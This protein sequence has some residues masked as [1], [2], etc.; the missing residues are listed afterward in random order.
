MEQRIRRHHTGR[1]LYAVCH[2]S[3]GWIPTCVGM[4]RAAVLTILLIIL[5]LFSFA[6]DKLT[7]T[8]A[9]AMY[10]EPKYKEDFKHFDYVNPNAPK[11]GA[12]KL[13]ATGS[14]DNLNFFLLKGVAPAGISMITESLTTRSDDE[15][16]S[17]YGLIAETMEVPE[18]RSYIIFNMRKEAKFQDGSL[19]T[20]D[21]VVFSFYTLKEKGHPVYKTYYQDI[22][23]VEKLDDRRVK[24]VF[25][26]TKNR[27]LPL[28]AGQMPILSKKYY[29]KV[30]FEK[31]TLTAPMG[32]GPYKVAAV[33]AGRSVTY[34]LDPNYWGKDLPVRIG[35]NNFDTIRY[36]YYRDD[37]VA[38]EAFKAGEY[39]FRQENIARNW[40]TA[41]D[42]PA[43]HNGKAKKEEIGH[44]IP[45][46]MQCFVFN[47]RRGK[48]ADKKLREALNMAFDFE[49]TNKNLFYG[50]Y[51]RTNSYFSN[52]EFASSGLPQGKELEI[53]SEY[54]DQLPEEVFGKE[55]V[56]PVSDGSGQ[57]R[58]LLVAAKNLLEEA[59]W[60]V[61]DGKLVNQ[62]GE[63]MNIEFL[64]NS[65]SFE[66]VIAPYI[67]NLEKLGIT[68]KIRMVD[69]AQYQKRLEEFDF[70][71]IM[72]VFPESMSPG[73]EQLDYWSSARADINGS[74][75][76]IGLK[77]KVVDAL[78]DKLL[79]A[80]DKESLVASAR[81]LDRVLLWG[82][83]VVPN[84]HIRSFRIIYWNK[85]GKPDVQPTYSLGFDNWWINGN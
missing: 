67:R 29:D 49:W 39:D 25:S 81:A 55:F 42:F 11:G 46:G 31:T 76:Y 1:R 66:R 51:T 56:L 19:V 43:L 72:N 58:K 23:S 64:I 69:T 38:V 65:P 9:I 71:V 37:T 75:N 26:N 22:S 80:N 83:Y 41:Y 68:G 36:D 77:N 50:A 53:L 30:D 7:K 12:V 44:S 5:P 73:N 63:G 27:E 4:T 20:A 52:S 15:P 78:V 61:K 82:Y 45:T 24:F 79:A 14:F 60:K 84:W 8:H 16:F 85:F 33:D 57:D 59:G 13:A 40:A 74:Q 62:K 47:T 35:T 54:K 3:L 17:Q 21:D 6:E 34:K 32:S 28:I 70:D 48:F 18:D 2:A 10:G